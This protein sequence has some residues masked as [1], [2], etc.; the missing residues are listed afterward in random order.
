MSNPLLTSINT[1]VREGEQLRGY[2]NRYL[3]TAEHPRGQILSA[4]RTSRNALASILKRQDA[5]MVQQAQQT[6]DEL[7]RNVQAAILTSLSMSIVLGQ[8]SAQIQIA[9]YEAV[10][11]SAQVA[12]QAPRPS[13]Y[14]AA[15]VAALD[16][17]LQAVNALIATGAAPEEVIGDGTRLGLLQPAPVQNETARW[18]RTA[19]TGGFI[20]WLI[21]TQPQAPTIER[22]PFRRQAIAGI[23][24]RTTNC[25]L[26]VH[27]QTVGMDEYFAL[28]GTPRYADRQKDPPFHDRC[29]TSVALYLAEYDDGYTDMMQEAA[30]L[31][32]QAR[33]SDNYKAPHPANAFTRVRR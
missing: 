18:L 1:A 27:G 6:L 5:T 8:E 3:G 19:V 30:Q 7:R 29:R 15:P 10:G 11:V 21:G 25:C 32:Q 14:S 24:E 16:Q 20:G 22:F 33:E 17:Q 4:Y 23:D 26:L 28:I 9:A 13:L 2:F 31:E 12:R